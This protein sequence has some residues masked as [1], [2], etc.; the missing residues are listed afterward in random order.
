MFSPVAIDFPLSYN[1][2]GQE[3]LRSIDGAQAGRRG[4]RRFPFYT[5]RMTS[6]ARPF[7][8]RPGRWTWV[9][10]LCLALALR[11]L[12]PGGYMPDP[13]ARAQGVLA[14]SICTAHNPSGLKAPII[15]AGSHTSSAHDCPLCLFA[16][17]L[18]GS[19]LA[20]ATALA[21]LTASIA[22]ILRIAGTALIPI[23]QERGAP[24]GPR[25]PP[26]PHR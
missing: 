21:P 2:R 5:S 23:F 3:T 14:L 18:S 16:H 17:H 19:P 13:D 9:W 10:A 12:V 24:L 11:A 6:T 7:V 25:A 15:P 22:A 4:I 26:H 1:L 8:W 20:T